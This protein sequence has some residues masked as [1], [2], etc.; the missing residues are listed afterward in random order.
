MQYLSRSA[1][2]HVF[3]RYCLFMLEV[4]ESKPL[5]LVK[6][7]AQIPL[8]NKKRVANLR[9][10]PFLSELRCG[11]PRASYLVWGISDNFPSGLPQPF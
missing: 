4:W 9:L 6:E 2:I 1:L 7:R 8:G 3:N 5:P 10:P 11:K